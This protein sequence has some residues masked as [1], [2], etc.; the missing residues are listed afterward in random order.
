M[1]VSGI[2]DTQPRCMFITLHVVF[3][4][5]ETLLAVQSFCRPR[6]LNFL[7]NRDSD[8]AT[9]DLEWVVLLEQTRI[10]GIA[11]LENL[12]PQQGIDASDENR[13]VL[14]LAGEKL[15]KAVTAS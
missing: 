5:G 6:D 2:D 1:I 10:F 7:S 12:R 14:R 13:N 8:Q 15:H 11:R 3:R 9:T 4:P